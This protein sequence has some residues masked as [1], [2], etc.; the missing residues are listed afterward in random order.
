MGSSKT[1]SFRD[2]Q[3]N[4]VTPSSTHNADAVRRAY[5]S[6]E[7][8]VGYGRSSGY[9]SDRHYADLSVPALLRCR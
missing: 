9:A 6:R 4:P 3:T 1:N 5:R 7:M 2:S 8:G